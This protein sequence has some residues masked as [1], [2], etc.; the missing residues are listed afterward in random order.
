MPINAL[1]QEVARGILSDCLGGEGSVVPGKHFREELGKEGLTIP[2]AWH[3]LR[4]GRIFKPPELDI[5]TRE[6]KYT[7]EGYTPDGTWLAIV[8]CL[9]QVNQAYLITVFSVETKRRTV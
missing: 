3:V 1:T 6:W 4:S 9:K 7:I 8:F 2:D 5:G